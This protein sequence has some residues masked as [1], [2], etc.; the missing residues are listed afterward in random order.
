VAGGAREAA[1]L[2]AAAWA[3]LEA[4]GARVDYVEV[5]HPTALT[6]VALAAPGSVM[7]LAAHVGRTR[8]IDNLVLP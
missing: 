3:R 6:P 1:P 8:L 2:V 4:A 7:L 5:V